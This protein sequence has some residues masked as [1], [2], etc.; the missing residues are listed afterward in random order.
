MKKFE[1]NKGLTL[2]EIIIVLTILVVLILMAIFAYRGQLAKGRDAKR[3]ADLNKLQN[4][5]ED[6]LNDYNCYSNDLVCGADFSPYL[7]EIPCDPV[8]DVHYNYFYS[9]DSGETTCKSWYKIYAKLENEKD[10]I[11]AEVGCEGGCGP[12]GN[13]NYWVSSPNMPDV[14]KLDGEIWPTIPGVPTTTP[15]PEP[16]VSPPVATP[17]PTLT[18]TPTPTF[19]SG[20]PTPTSAPTPTPTP[21]PIPSCIEDDRCNFLRALWPTECG[22]FCPGSEM[23]CVLDNFNPMC[24][25]DPDCQ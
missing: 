10:P 4:V 2:I 6:Y 16:T 25:L 11:I 13:Y 5:L 22:A 3:K 8:N 17:T 20:T 12:S 19:P 24:C 18:P 14:N 21:T 15:T 23:R 9:N 1:K 7:P